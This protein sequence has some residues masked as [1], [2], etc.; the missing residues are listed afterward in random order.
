MKT[1]SSRLVKL[2]FEVKIRDPNA[3]IFPEIRDEFNSKFHF[4]RNHFTSVIRDRILNPV[5]INFYC[6]LDF[7]FGQKKVL[8]KCHDILNNYLFNMFVPLGKPRFP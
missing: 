8:L 2:L 1:D 5:N 4:F 6:R 7:N 3:R